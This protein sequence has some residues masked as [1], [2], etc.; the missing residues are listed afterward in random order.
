M[1]FSYG[2]LLSFLEPPTSEEHRAFRKHQILARY[3]LDLNSDPTFWT[4]FHSLPRKHFHDSHHGSLPWGELTTATIGSAIF[5]GA[6]ALFG[7][8]V[9]VGNF[10]NHHELKHMEPTVKQQFKFNGRYAW[11][12]IKNQKTWIRI[13]VAFAFCDWML[14]HY[15]SPEFPSRH[16]YVSSMVAG[17]AFAAVKGPWAATASAL[18]FMGFTTLFVVGSKFMDLGSLFGSPYED[19]DCRRM[20]GVPPPPPKTG[21]P[22]PRDIRV[23]HRTE[24]RIQNRQMMYQQQMMQQQ[25]M[26]GM[27]GMEPEL[28]PSPH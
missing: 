17:A 27:V 15:W 16:Q 20:P 8:F 18:G 10:Q 5:G 4:R 26:A 6:F 23:L 11:N 13:G 1:T 25:G 28:E 14:M 24:A 22:L 21:V 12:R 19:I 3:Y 2:F 9:S 7:I